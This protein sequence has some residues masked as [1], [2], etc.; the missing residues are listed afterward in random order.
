MRVSLHDLVTKR[1]S[2]KFGT[3]A[4]VGKSVGIQGSVSPG[5]RRDSEA[6]SKVPGSSGELISASHHG[7][8]LLGVSA[9]ET[10]VDRRETTNSWHEKLRTTM[11]TKLAMFLSFMCSV[12]MLIGRDIYL[13]CAASTEYDTAAFQTS[14][15]VMV[16]SILENFAWSQVNEPNI[17]SHSCPVSTIESTNCTAMS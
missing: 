6:L 8:D 4:A 5:P 13:A 15:F 2:N 3:E 16:S 10:V 9:S 1:T 12:W 7:G 14:T 17:L 11:N